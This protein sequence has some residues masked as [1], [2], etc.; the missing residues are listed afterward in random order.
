VFYNFQFAKI[1]L[2]Q[3]I[4]KSYTDSINKHLFH[5]YWKCLCV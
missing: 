4:K 1:Q 2:E 3:L 5:S